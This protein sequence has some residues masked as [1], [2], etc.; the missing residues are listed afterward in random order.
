MKNTHVF[1]LPSG[2]E[3]EVEELTGKQQRIL[4]EQNGKP[5]TEK[6]AEMLASVLVR[7]GTSF[8]PDVKFVQEEMLACDIKFALTEVR[9]FSL[10]FEP[11]FSFMHTYKDVEGNK[12]EVEIEED[13]P[14]GRFPITTVK[15]LVTP[16][17]GGEPELVDANYTEYADIEKNIT[18]TL[19]KS[20]KKVRFT[21]LDGKG[22]TIGSKTKKNERSSHTTIMMR[23]PVYFEE[24]GK[25]NEVPIQLNLDSL[26]LK[27]IE[28]L[29]GEIKK[30]EGQ[31]DTEI[32]VERPDSDTRPANEKDMIVDVLSVVSFFFPSEAI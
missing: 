28:F 25:G 12:Q 29:R 6:L 18:V 13:I 9:Q 10:D 5:H 19:P 7:V 3:C 24:S 11:S 31:V 16:E 1:T 21:M 23:R 17:G 15:K 22:T 32:M 14:E 26:P 30:Y 27:D 8:R 20:G 2:V 4:T